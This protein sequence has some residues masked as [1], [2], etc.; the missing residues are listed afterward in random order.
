MNILSQVHL[1]ADAK[2]K[3]ETSRTNGGVVSSDKKKAPD[4]EQQ[5]AAV[6]A[7]I[8]DLQVR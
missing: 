6:L 3:K 5:L 4:I 7:H 1:P 2:E 8:E